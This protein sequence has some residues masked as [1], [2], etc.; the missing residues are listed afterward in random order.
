MPPQ[1]NYSQRAI[2]AQP[3]M[4]FDA[5]MFARDAVSAICA[6]NI[7]F[8]AACEFLG[9][10]TGTQGTIQPLQGSNLAGTVTVTNASTAITFTTA[11]TLPAGQALVFSDQPGVVYYLSAAMS[12]ATSGVLT[13]T[14]SGTGGAAKL[15]STSPYS[16]QFAGIAMFDELGVEQN[17]TSW[18]IPTTLAGTVSVANASASITFSVA[19]TLAAGASLVF[20][21]QPGVLYFVQTATAASTACTLTTNYLGVTAGTATTV[22]PQQGSSAS[23]WRAGTAVPLFRRG[24][25][26]GLSDAGGTPLQIGPINVWHS[27]TGTSPRGIFTFTATSQ[28]AGAEIDIAPGVTAWNPG[29]Q[30]AALQTDPFGNQVR[31]TP[32]EINI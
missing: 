2:L 14:Y 4:P 9:G 16:P 1:V 6:V 15:A 8:G 22:L 30:Y 7:P 11:Q 32:L 18:T 10:S 20:S 24:R 5:G 25:I 17:Y 19:Q 21:S 27:S 13:Q 31:V 12:A 23:G 28:T 3:G 29:V 26:W